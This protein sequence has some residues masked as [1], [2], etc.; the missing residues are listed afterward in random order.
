MILGGAENHSPTRY[1]F[2]ALAWLCRPVSGSLSHHFHKL[3]DMTFQWHYPMSILQ[4]NPIVSYLCYCLC[5]R[6]P[7]LE[8]LHPAPNHLSPLP[9]YLIIQFSA[10]EAITSMK[11]FLTVH[12]LESIWSCSP[13]VKSSFRA[14]LMLC[15]TNNPCMCLV[16][17]HHVAFT[18][19]FPV[20]SSDSASAFPAQSSLFFSSSTYS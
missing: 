2:K 7:Q 8:L 18:D 12:P 11:P 17:I 20:S 19:E 5:H 3:F 16:P 13:L 10:Q 1:K 14:L 6:S 9:Q 15:I 4:S